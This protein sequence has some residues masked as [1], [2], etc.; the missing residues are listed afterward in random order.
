MIERV[1]PLILRTLKPCITSDHFQVAL[2]AAVFCSAP[3]FIALFRA[4]PDDLTTFL[5]FSART[6]TAHWNPETRE[7]A[8]F[9]VDAVKEFEMG[10]KPATRG[11]TGKNPRRNGRVGWLE[12]VDIAADAD[13]EIN[14][15]SEKAK[16]DAWLGQI[17]SRTG[18]S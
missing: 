2:N 1:G 4:I 18:T 5:L 14:R 9:L 6:A 17:G 13:S 11:R 7:V 3:E 16:Y 8:E 15:E 12:I 10:S